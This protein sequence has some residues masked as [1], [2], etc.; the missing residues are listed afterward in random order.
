MNRNS[1]NGVRYGA[2]IVGRNGLAF[3][4]DTSLGHKWTEVMP[5]VGEML[6]EMT[7]IA[8]EVVLASGEGTAPQ[9]TPMNVVL[10]RPD[11]GEFTPSEMESLRWMVTHM[12]LEFGFASFTTTATIT[13]LAGTGD[14]PV[15]AA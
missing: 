3:E 4:L 2:L 6:A 7:G 14:N 5:V 9:G 13:R 11:E 15:V 1:D 10:Y 12:A 8:H